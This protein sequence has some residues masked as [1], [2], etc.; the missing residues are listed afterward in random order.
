MQKEVDRGSGIAAVSVL[1]VLLYSGEVTMQ[2][3][4]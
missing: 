1:W 3:A 4:M 2:T